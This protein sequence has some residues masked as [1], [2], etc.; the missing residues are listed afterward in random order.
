MNDP[1]ADLVEVA[2]GWLHRRSGYD[3]AA[4]LPNGRQLLRDLLL[5]TGVLVPR[6]GR[7]RFT[8]QSF[9]EFF[10]ARAIASTFDET[11]WRH[12]M[13]N[14]AARSLAAFMAATGPDPD[15]L[16]AGLLDSG[17]DAVVAGDLL[18][19]G[20]AVRP[21]TRQRVIDSLV[22]EVS[23]N[24]TG[25]GESL[26]VLRE[27]SVDADVLRRLTDLA[28]DETVNE[29]SR[30]VV[31][32]AVADV[33][34]AT[35]IRLLRLAARTADPI[36]R[37]WAVQALSAR[38]AAAGPVEWEPVRGGARHPLGALG[39]QALTDRAS[40]TG[41][42]DDERV[43]AALR[44]AHDGEL[45][46]VRGLLETPGIDD[47][48]RL[49]AAHALAAYGDDSA[50]LALAGGSTTSDYYVPQSTVDHSLRYCALRHLHW[51]RHPASVDLLTAFVAGTSAPCT[52]GAAAMLAEVG[53]FDALVDVATG[54]AR[55]P[56][57]RCGRRETPV[58]RRRRGDP[59][60]RD[61]ARDRASGSGLAGRGAGS[62]RADAPRP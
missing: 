30:L 9:A 18:A 26:R 40:D 12:L 54:S 24:T 23:G 16:V 47:G 4:V 27:L 11:G 45:G 33:D 7:L 36:A 59:G 22:G 42:G 21:D 5:A 8:H 48:G 13:A 46:A 14:P 19:D 10:A 6:G 17:F 1:E 37:G 39:R 32:D 58:D 53:R 60:T 43:D 20:V 35:G 25:S 52:Y 49:R 56:R 55:A 29:W 28:T 51:R 41:I 57:A 61:G 2:G 15:R 3:L 34:P 62:S 50:L 31:A 44:L 38:G